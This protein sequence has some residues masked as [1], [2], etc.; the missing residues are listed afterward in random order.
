MKPKFVQLP[1]LPFDLPVE[2]IEAIWSYIRMAEEDRVMIQEFMKENVNGNVKNIGKTAFVKMMQDDS[3]EI[4][5]DVEE[6]IELMRKLIG[7]L[8]AQACEIAALVYEH[9]RMEGK[10]IEKISDEFHLD[11]ELLELM[12]QYYDENIDSLLL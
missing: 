10:S 2:S 5:P 8:M 3:T 6:Y 11:Q 1:P 4:T 9:Y 12:A 7:T